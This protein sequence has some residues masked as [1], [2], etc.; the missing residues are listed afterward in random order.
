[1]R[2]ESFLVVGMARIQK[3]LKEAP[4]TFALQR[5]SQPGNLIGRFSTSV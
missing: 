4:F 5:I 2:M 1:M 3:V